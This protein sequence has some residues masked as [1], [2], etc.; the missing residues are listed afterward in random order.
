MKII[1][2]ISSLVRRKPLT[3]EELAA[4]TEVERERDEARIAGIKR[5]GGH[6]G[7]DPGN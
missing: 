1:K 2:K 4:R 7:W 6:G 5:G 3:E